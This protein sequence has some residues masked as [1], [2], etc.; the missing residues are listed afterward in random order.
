MILSDLLF[1][2]NPT[3]WKNEPVTSMS[4]FLPVAEKRSVQCSTTFLKLKTGAVD[5]SRALTYP[6]ACSGNK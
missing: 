3:V 4:S 1:L 5:F 6:F 2:F